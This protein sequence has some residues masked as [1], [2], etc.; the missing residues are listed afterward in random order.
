MGRS[1]TKRRKSSAGKNIAIFFIV[2]TLLEGLII[3]G[4]TRVFSN[5]N[6]VISVAGYSFFLMDSDNMGQEP[7]KDSLVIVSNGVPSSDKCG[8]TV[9]AKNVGDQGTTVG[10]LY[11]VGAKGDT[12]DHVV[13]TIY[14]EKAPDK[15]YDLKS[16]DIVG[17]A[18]SYYLTA[19]KI[20]SFVLTPFGMIVVL[21]APIVLMIL[22]ELIVAIAHRSHD[23]YDYIDDT[24]HV[25]GNENLTLDDF[26]YGGQNDEVYTSGKPKG[27]F[28]EEFEEAVEQPQSRQ[29]QRS[30][31]P[32]FGVPVSAPASVPEPEPVY[33]E[34]QIAEPEPAPQ[35]EQPAAAEP[36]PENNAA[37]DPYY[38]ERASRMIDGMSDDEAAQAAEAPAAAPAAQPELS[39]EN[40]RR[41]QQGQ[42]GGGQRRRPPQ[43]GRPNGQRRRPAPHR[44]AAPRKDANATLEELMKL[45][46]DEQKKLRDTHSDN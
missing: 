22:L 4:L 30:E 36:A 27:S 14:Q 39:Q 13:Y 1:Q 46:E 25:A 24:E 9:L 11:E 21:A 34:P 45:M 3:F 10:W 43:G 40:R 23:D 28:E 2:F 8:Y 12:V 20:I 15:M 41:P 37:V 32:D 6:S 17:Q 42:Q 26:L 29:P 16:A 5:E 35:P 44:P 31:R 7:P 33:E 18:T 38:Y 19:G